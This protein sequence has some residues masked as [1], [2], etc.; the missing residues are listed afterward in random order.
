MHIASN[1]SIVLYLSMGE[2]L[3]LSGKSMPYNSIIII[4]DP[5]AEYSPTL[6]CHI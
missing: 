2:I 1:A 5:I 3:T 4:I 6:A